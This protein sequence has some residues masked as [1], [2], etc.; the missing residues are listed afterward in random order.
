MT[1]Y[2][3]SGGQNVS[4]NAARPTSSTASSSPRLTGDN[5]AES[6]EEIARRLQQQEE[7]GRQQVRAPIAPRRDILTGGGSPFEH[8]SMWSSPAGSSM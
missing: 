2:L 6:D 8:N 3:E 1:L 7:R 4:Q 5:A